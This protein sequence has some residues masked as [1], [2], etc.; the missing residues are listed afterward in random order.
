MHSDYLAHDAIGLAALVRERKASPRELLD[1]A[2]G[3]A[4]AVN[5]AVNAIVLQDYDAARK[6]AEPAADAGAN[7]PFAGVPYLV[8]DLGAAVAGLPLSMG[9]RH[10][11]YFVPADDS[12]V[13]AR[14]RAAGLN[15][16][17]K[18]NPSEIGQMPYTEPQL[19][20]ECRNQWNL[21]HTPGGS[22]GGAAAAVAAGI[23][24][25]AHASD[26]GGSIRIP[27]SCCGLF[28]LKPSRNP[29]LVDLPG[30]PGRIVRSAAGGYWLTVFAPRSQ[31][32][33]F[34]LRERT[35]RERMMREI[36]E[37]FW[38]APSLH[39]ARDYR[40]ERGDGRSLS[41]DD[42]VYRGDDG[43]YYCKRSDGTTGLVVG[44][45]AGAALGAILGGGG[46]LGTLL[47]AGGGGLLGH[48]VDKGEVR[49][50]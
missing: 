31:L 48:S 17:G 11:R 37:E 47:G 18:T 2:I 29:L 45:V 6:R 14:S 15:V 28:G 7:A 8:K 9:S 16:F 1:A 39:P 44:A 41:R 40:E 13:I 22:S 26:G 34:V 25:I 50:R 23:V 32:I 30:Y 19:F 27:A 24:P 38:V 3:Q 4:E 36:D 20:G 5:G 46:L 33:E 10:Y 35:Y 42:R 12:P 21:D 49:C 43:R